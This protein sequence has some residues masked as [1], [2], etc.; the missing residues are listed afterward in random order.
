MDY[1][2]DSDTSTMGTE[3]LQYLTKNPSNTHIHGLIRLSLHT[4]IS[5]F[6]ANCKSTFVVFAALSGTN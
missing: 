6:H 4:N 3:V 5:L 1:W 2:C